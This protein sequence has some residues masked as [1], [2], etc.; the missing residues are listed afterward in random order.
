MIDCGPGMVMHTYD[1]STQGQEDQEFKDFLHYVRPYGKKAETKSILPPENGAVEVGS[2][3]KS[4]CPTFVG[5]RVQIP[6]F[7]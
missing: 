1:P 7:V 4:A 6:T 3:I 5:T 2:V